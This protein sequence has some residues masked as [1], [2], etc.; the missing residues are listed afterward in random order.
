MLVCAIF[1]SS[2]AT[3]SISLLLRTRKKGR[4][5]L[6]LARTWVA[7][8]DLSARFLWSRNLS[9]T[10][11]SLNQRWI[12]F[13]LIAC[14]YLIQ[15]FCLA[16]TKWATKLAIGFSEFWNM[17]GCWTARR[18]IIVWRSQETIKRHTG[19]IRWEP[20]EEAVRKTWAK[21]RLSRVVKE[22]LLNLLHTHQQLIYWLLIGENRENC[23][24]N[25]T[26]ALNCCFLLHHS[27]CPSTILTTCGVASCQ[28]NFGIQIPQV[29]PLA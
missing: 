2:V 22:C 17:Y 18:Q 6:R 23:P 26:K 10:I 19:P 8:I 29:T 24:K 15:M 12:N 21:S 4:F 1:N 16:S 25:R 27:R 7:E 5:K 14:L 11:H 9:T 20:A 28:N 3:D 13:G